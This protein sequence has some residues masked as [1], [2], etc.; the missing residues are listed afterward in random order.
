[1]KPKAVDTYRRVLGYVK[2]Y[3]WRIVISIIASLGIASSD[4]ILA[5]LVQPFIDRLVIEGDRDLARW[6]PIMVISV[7]ALKGCSMYIQRY[8]IQTA[9]QL[10]LLDLRNAL[11][12][13]LVNLSM[14]FYSRTSVGVLMSRILND[15]NVMQ[16]IVSEVLVSAMKDSI[17]LVALIGVALYTDWE[18]TVI[19]LLVLPATGA[20]VVLIGRKIKNYSRRGQ[21][22]MGLVTSTLE[23]TFSGI[24]VIKS[25]SAEA[26]SNR[27]FQNTNRYFYNFIRKIFKYDSG[28]SPII[29]ILSAFGVAGVL[30]FGLDRA[31]SGEMTQ[32]ELFSVLAAI[33]L[34]YAPLKRLTRVNN[35]IQQALAAAER[36]FEVLDEPCDVKDKSGALEVVRLKG[37]ITFDSVDFS[38]AEALVLKEFSLEIAPGEVVA[39]VGPSGAGKSTL[40]GMLSRF[41]DPVSGSIAI[42]GHDLRDLT[43]NSLRSNI[44]LV[45]QETFLFDDT[46]YNNISFGYE[47]AS[48]EDVFEAARQAYADEFVRLLPNGYNTEI[49]SRG[50]NVSGGQR[51]RICIARA[52][53]K[54]APILLLDEATSALDTESEAKV[55]MALSNLMKGRTTLVIAHRLSTVM[56]AD[57][58]VV[59]D[60]GQIVQVGT[61]K[62][63]LE[64]GGLYRKLY[65][66]QFEQG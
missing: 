8:F 9:G 7:A 58:I 24:K 16:S 41:Y 51:Q 12:E 47:N 14:S 4:A 18:M 49:G 23:Q 19:A 30:W 36:V 26:K 57:K 2:P 64:S 40:I 38:Y 65:E 43:Q 10:T 11:Y 54:N 1:M 34:M 5:K 61:H 66:I 22:A 52:I 42:D 6:V 21:Q 50:L 45:D 60:Q 56:H 44:A 35:Q 55:Q 63:L 33:L 29:E 13:H 31:L 20:P 46:V 32:G 17:T 28:S 59:M 25:F 15:V 39:L 48:E 62:E 37:A 53:L 3:R 27:H